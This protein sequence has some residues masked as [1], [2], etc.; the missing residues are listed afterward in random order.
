MNYIQ[1]VH[2]H[3]T[4]RSLPDIDKES[5]QFMTWYWHLVC[6]NDL[7]VRCNCWVWLHFVW[8]HWDFYL[9]LFSYIWPLY[10][11]RYQRYSRRCKRTMFWILIVASHEK[12]G[13]IQQVPTW[14]NRDDDERS[15]LDQNHPSFFS[16]W[17]I[18]TIFFSYLS[19]SWQCWQTD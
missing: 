12:N 3:T 11:E 9:V 19:T 4:Q 18:I 16:L 14:E 10:Y 5:L 8:H 2:I 7:F 17:V 15:I 6:I 13:T 1:T